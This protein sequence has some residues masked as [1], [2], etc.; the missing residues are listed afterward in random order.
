M[1]FTNLPFIIA[2]I[3][4]NH[5][6]SLDHATKMIKSASKAGA[7]AVKF[8]TYKAGKI[9]S[10][11]S[12]SYWDTSKE[13]TK[14]QFE[15]F[16]KYDSFD[17]EDYKFLKKTCDENNIEFMSTA[18]DLDSIEFIDPLVKRHKISSSDITNKPLISSIGAK[19]KPIILSTGA[20]NLEEIRQAL[21]WLSNH[22]VE[23]SLLHC[24]LE[25]PTP[26]LSANLSRISLLKNYFPKLTIGYSD[27]TLPQNNEVLKAATFL[28]AEIIEKHYTYNKNLEGNDHYH[29][30]DESDLQAFRYWLDSFYKDVIST[31][32]LNLTYNKGEEPARLNARRGVYVKTDINPGEKITKQMLICK[33]P[34]SGGIEPKEIDEIIGLKLTKLAE[35]DTPLS[36]SHFC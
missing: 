7:N 16:S 13:K 21:S 3:G 14:N 12:P 26:N 35:E 8:Q 6:G 25:Y 31:G 11:N 19:K 18:F 22:K 27:H 9:A 34:Y 30:M 20:S 17:E 28:G 5:G 23:V 2:E 15:L 29:S 33:R 32:E 36:K 24:V 4:V 10:K 1:N